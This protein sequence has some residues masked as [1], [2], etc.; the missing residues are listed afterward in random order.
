MGESPAATG[1]AP[2]REGWGEAVDPG[3]S[4]LLLQYCYPRNAV[5]TA[6][7]IVLGH[8]F[9]VHFSCSN[10]YFLGPE[11]N[12]AT[13]IYEIISLSVY[14]NS[15]SDPNINYRLINNSKVTCLNT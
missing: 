8:I 12:T 9:W 4:N 14:D 11:T 10:I 1:P 7:V 3:R 2:L 5:G 6:N 13:K 15:W